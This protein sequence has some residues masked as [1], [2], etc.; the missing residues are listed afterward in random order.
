MILFLWCYS[1]LSFYPCILTLFFQIEVSG[2]LLG[3]LTKIRRKFQQIKISKLLFWFSQL[4]Y[5]I[6]IMFLPTLHIKKKCKS[7]LGELKCVD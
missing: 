2:F 7:N 3:T 4:K 1:L 6:I 5:Q